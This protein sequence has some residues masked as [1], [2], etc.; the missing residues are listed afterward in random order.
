MHSQIPYWG[1]GGLVP[2]FFNSPIAL[3]TSLTVRSGDAGL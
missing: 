2:P 1:I 3:T